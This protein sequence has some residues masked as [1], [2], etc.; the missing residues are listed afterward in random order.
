MTPKWTA[1][2]SPASIAPLSPFDLPQNWTRSPRKKRRFIA[3]RAIVIGEN[4]AFP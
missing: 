1:G 4:P 3:A 2:V